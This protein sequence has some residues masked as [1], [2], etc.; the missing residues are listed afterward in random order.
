MLNDTLYSQWKHAIETDGVKLNKEIH[1]FPDTDIDMIFPYVIFLL[2]TKG[3]AHATYDLQEITLSANT[4]AVFLPGHIL[5]PINFTPDFTFSYAAISAD[6]KEELKLEFFSHDYS[7]FH[8]SPTC[9]LDETQAN[10][11]LAL[12]EITSAIASHR[13]DDLQLRRR[14]LLSQMAVGYEFINYYRRTQDEQ[15]KVGKRA[16]LYEQ[17][18]DLVVTHY[19]ENRNIN[20]YANL[21]G[22]DGRYFSKIFQQ[23]SHGMSPL[24]WIQRYVAMRAKRIIDENPKQTIKE[25]A[26]QLGFPTSSNFCRYFKRATGIYPQDYKMRG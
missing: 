6:M 23:L 13:P 3:S 12:V 26:F 11:L 21:L 14:M 20:Y 1:G 4:L 15:R 8:T 5:R 7:K 16:T 19:K 25:T 18:C 10:R 17:F 2:C 24:E 22:Y 9:L